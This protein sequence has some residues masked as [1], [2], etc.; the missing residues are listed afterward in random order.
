VH[1]G[2][3]RGLVSWGGMIR[4]EGEWVVSCLGGRGKGGR[5]E[6]ERKGGLRREGDVERGRLAGGGTIGRRSGGFVEEF[7]AMRK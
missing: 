3:G 6:E 7:S 4:K 2:H 5:V 1:C